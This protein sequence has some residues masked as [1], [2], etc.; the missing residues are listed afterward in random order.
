MEKYESN[1]N[2][3]RPSRYYRLLRDNEQPVEDGIQAKDPCAQVDLTCHVENG[4]YNKSQYISCTETSESVLDWGKH[5]I[6]NGF[7]D[8]MRIAVIDA[9]QLDLTGGVTIYDC[10]WLRENLKT[11]KAINFA[12]EYNEVVVEGN[13]GQEYI[14][15]VIE[16]TFSDATFSDAVS[17]YVKKGFE[18]ESDKRITELGYMLGFL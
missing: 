16:A 9:V 18:K 12:N 3:E 5:N 14:V 17:E 15:Q 11:E 1:A 8:H 7:S 2:E 4:S 6:R 10:E 13:I